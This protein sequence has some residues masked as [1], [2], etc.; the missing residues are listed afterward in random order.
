MNQIG[1]SAIATSVPSKV[2]TNFD[3]EKMVDTTDEWIITRTGIRERHILNPDESITDFVINS[4]KEACQK[5]NLTA[6]KIEFIISS[7]LSPNRISPAQAFEVAKGIGAN[8]MFGFDLNAACSGFTYGIAIAESL[9]KTRQLKYGLVTAGEQVSRFLDYTDRASCV[10]F[11][12]AAVAA[13][14]TSEN[15]EH[16]IIA[17]EMGAFPS[18][19]DEVT[20]GGV[21]HLINDQRSDYYFRQNGKSIFK[22]AVNKIKE[23]YETFPAKVGLKPEQI[24]YIIPHQANMRILDAAA[25]DIQNNG[26]IF[27]NNLEKYGNTSSASIGLVLNDEWQRFQKGDYLLLIGF[28]GGLSWGATLIEW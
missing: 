14:L 18:M 21:S 22:F 3:L 7:T 26:T 12:D 13:V 19:A 9:M 24:K 23:I 25:K 11:G 20:I 28:G 15:P 2:L 6:E 4:A 17:T 27:L 10:I 8:Q 5:A 1:I 16:L